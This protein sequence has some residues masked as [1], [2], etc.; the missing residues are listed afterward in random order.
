[1][2]LKFQKKTNVNRAATK[3]MDGCS[4]SFCLSLNCIY[5]YHW[6]C[7]RKIIDEGF[8][9]RSFLLKEKCIKLVASVSSFWLEKKL[10][11]SIE[12]VISC[13]RWLSRCSTH[14][15]ASCN[16]INKQNEQTIKEKKKKREE[17]SQMKRVHNFAR[18]WSLPGKLQFNC[19]KT[20]ASVEWICMWMRNQI[21]PADGIMKN[22]LNFSHDCEFTK[23]KLKINFFVG[24]YW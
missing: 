9:G 14:P 20:G 5:I 22:T 17:I 7:E 11:N 16:A 10:M 21:L 3:F 15:T 13:C 24:W 4:F 1:M 12:K 2:F 23:T 8:F 19:E 6:W 18:A